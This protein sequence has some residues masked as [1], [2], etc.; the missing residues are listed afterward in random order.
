MNA[1]RDVISVGV[2]ANEDVATNV[3]L[4]LLSPTH[5]YPCCKD[6]V[7]VPVADID[8]DTDNLPLGINIV[9]SPGLAGN[10]VCNVST[11]AAPP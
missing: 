11:L 7:N 3:V 6:D 2:P 10:C 1:F 5:T 8:D 4:L 9:K